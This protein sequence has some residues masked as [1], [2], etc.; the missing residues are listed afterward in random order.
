MA[1]NDEMII[2]AFIAFIVLPALFMAFRAK[3]LDRPQTGEGKAGKAIAWEKWVKYGLCAILLVPFVPMSIDGYLLLWNA[4]DIMSGFAVSLHLC[5]LALLAVLSM[6]QTPVSKPSWV[7]EVLFW[8]TLFSLA[9]ISAIVCFAVVATLRAVYKGLQPYLQDRKA[10]NIPEPWILD[11][12][13]PIPRKGEISGNFQSYPYAFTFI[14]LVA[15]VYGSYAGL[16]GKIF[17]APIYGWAALFFLAGIPLIACLAFVMAL[18][19]LYK[20]WRQVLRE[21]KSLGDF[22]RNHSRA[23]TLVVI[24]LAIGGYWKN[25]PSYPAASYTLW[26]YSSAGFPSEPNTDEKFSFISTSHGSST[27]MLEPVEVDGKYGYADKSGKIVIAPIYDEVAWQDLQSFSSGGIL[28][29]VKANG[30]YGYIDRK[31][32]E[33]TP[34][35]FDEA[36]Q[37]SGGCSGMIQVRIGEK[38]GWIDRRGKEITLPLYD[39]TVEYP[40]K[41][42]GLPW[43]LLYVFFD[44]HPAAFDDYPMARI[45]ADGKWGYIDVRGKEMI[46]PRYDEI[47]DEDHVKGDVLALVREGNQ[48]YWIDFDGKEITPAYLA[49]ADAGNLRPIQLGDKWGYASVDGIVMILPHFDQARDFRANGQA[50]AMED[51][52]WVFIDA[53]GKIQ[54]RF[55]TLAEIDPPRYEEVDEFSGTSG[56]ARVKRDGKWGYIDLRGKEV[57]LPQYEEAGRFGANRWAMVKRDGKFGLIDSSGKE[58]VSPRFDEILRFDAN[59]LARVRQNGKWGYVNAKGTEVIAPRFDDA[60]FASTATKQERV[61]MNGKWG[62][63]DL[64]GKEI[65]PLRFDTILDGSLV[66]KDDVLAL[67]GE[68]GKW[69]WLDMNGKEIVP[70]RILHADIERLTRTRVDMGGNEA[71]SDGQFDRSRSL[72]K[73]GY[74]DQWGVIIIPPRFDEASYGFN[75][76]GLASVKLDGKWGWIDGEGQTVI[77]LRFDEV[78]I[79]SFTERGDRLALVRIGGKWGGIDAQGE[80]IIPFHF[81]E[82]ARFNTLGLAR[83]KL[84]GKL[85]WVDQQGESVILPR[86]DVAADFGKNTRLAKVGVGE[87]CVGNLRETDI[88]QRHSLS[89]R[90]GFIDIRGREIVPLR[91]DEI[92]EFDDRGLAVAN[93]AGKWGVVDIRGKEI[94]P[95]RFSE[96]YFDRRAG[97]DIA[98]LVRQD[99]NTWTWFDRKGHAVTPPYVRHAEAG[100]LQLWKNAQG[101]MGY[102]DLVA[103]IVI[104]PRFE[105]AKDFS[106][107]GVARV[108]IGKDCVASRDRNQ[109]P[110]ADGQRH[111]SPCRWGIIDARG[112]EII[113]PRFD[114]IGEFDDQG[115]AV[116]SRAGKWGMVDIRG[117]EIVPLRFAELYFGERVG[118][119]AALVREGDTW[120]WF[121]HNGRAVIPAHVR[122]ADAKELRAWKS[123]RNRV[124]YVDRQGRIVIAPRFDEAAEGFIDAGKAKVKLKGQWQW[125]DKRGGEVK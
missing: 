49:E 114:V 70:A 58:F 22:F 119:A 10:K 62:L 80:T 55:P 61:A 14:L 24:L 6:K 120:R 125:V 4:N 85:G 107:H 43:K 110:D 35:H 18:R 60:G 38:W 27:D 116:A 93:R 45:M 33:V 42:P 17:L 98:A 7:W 12:E 123:A 26:A 90:W 78:D 56:L 16:P 72:T 122:A 81:D 97:H 48:W 101:R 100:E 124:G 32:K 117:K 46:P 57:V 23:V 67:V 73:Y 113:S 74:A 53:N 105:V 54:D 8:I 36:P 104:P 19:T 51:G 47:Y 20:G 102:V 121:N 115:L 91:F 3:W 39:E 64:Q 106:F 69:V 79:E 59:G 66:A 1:R 89:C 21:G 83:V 95:P 25:L 9:N 109:E 30:K 31:G 65:L 63:V 96:I 94:V 84:D 41:C 44:V 15:G 40:M 5:L 77:P 76:Q 28:A 118:E 71:W 86:F 13:T 103:R 88:G 92:E 99:N 111:S 112:K 108:A 29:R 37:L 75:K 34:L 87:G 82:I 52:K 11:Q 2:A 50:I 68:G